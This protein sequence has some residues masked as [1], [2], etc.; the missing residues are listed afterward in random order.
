MTITIA[1]GRGALWQW[2]TGRRVGVQ[3]H[4]HRRDDQDVAEAEFQLQGRLAPQLFALCR[5]PIPQRSASPADFV[6]CRL[7]SLADFLP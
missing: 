7:T 5:D 2:D 6:P 4:Q 1:D 3:Q